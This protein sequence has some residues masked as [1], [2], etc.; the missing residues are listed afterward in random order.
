MIDVFQYSTNKDFEHF[1]SILLKVENDD[2]QRLAENSTTG[3]IA[4]LG[5]EPVSRLGTM[6]IMSLL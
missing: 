4:I 6:G 2:A 3:Q 1:K 5:P